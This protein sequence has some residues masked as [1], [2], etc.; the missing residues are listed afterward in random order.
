VAPPDNSSMATPARVFDEGADR[1]GTA[2]GS[3]PLDP[4]MLGLEIR[5]AS[6]LCRLLAMVGKDATDV[7]CH[8]ETSG[9]RLDVHVHVPWPVDAALRQAIGVKVLDALWGS[10]IPTFGDA[11]VDIDCGPSFG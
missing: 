7:R 5:M 10:G 4:V 6:Q 2:R 11:S 8:I 9:P 1:G 3:V